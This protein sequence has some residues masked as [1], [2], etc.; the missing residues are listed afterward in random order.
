VPR[1]APVACAWGQ[2]AFYVFDV[3][4]AG[5]IYQH[6]VRAGQW[7]PREV[8]TPPSRSR[9]D[10]VAAISPTAAVPLQPRGS[11]LPVLA[12]VS[13]QG[14][15]ARTDGKRWRVL[16]DPDEAPLP[17][18]PLSRA[19]IAK[20]PSGEGLTVLVLDGD[21]RIWR[22]SWDTD[23]WAVWKETPSPVQGRVTALAIDP[24]GGVMDAV[25]TAEGRIC[26]RT[27][28]LQPVTRDT[29]RPVVD[30]AYSSAARLH[31]CVFALDNAGTIWHLRDLLDPGG[32][33]QSDWAAL[34][35][36]AG[37]VTGIASDKIGDGVGILLAATS[38]GTHYA[39]YTVSPKG[40]LQW[41][42]WT[43]LP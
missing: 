29:G 7:A 9:P 11:A 33:K 15:W 31:S 18:L 22:R 20:R 27:S 16:Y 23:V 43:R 39:H 5:R 42:A 41:S 24:T 12:I 40:D 37:Q 26:Y 17:R 1:A 28:I 30:V 8:V 36:P 10:Y 4:G 32:H 6:V 21:N 38:G 25:G 13:E 3:D 14:A 2:D 34:P 35:G 19:T